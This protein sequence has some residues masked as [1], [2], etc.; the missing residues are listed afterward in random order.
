[1]K[2]E[3]AQMDPSKGRRR[4]FGSKVGRRP[5]SL[6]VYFMVLVVLVALGFLVDGVTKVNVTPPGDFSLAGDPLGA[7]GLSVPVA[8][9]PTGSTTAWYCTIS[10]QGS[11]ATVPTL[12]LYNA[13]K[14]RS[15]VEIF[16]SISSGKAARRVTLLPYGTVTVP[17]SS[18]ESKKH[19]S[20]VSVVAQGGRP[21]AAESVSFG[22]QLVKS[23]CQSTPGF[24]W[25]VTGLYTFARDSANVAIY[26]PFATPAVVDVSALTAS[27]EVVPGNFQGII[28]G[29]GQTTVI[30]LDRVIPP[31]SNLAVVVRARSGRIVVGSLQTRSDKYARGL[32]VPQ[33]T[34]R[35]STLWDY[36]YVRTSQ[37]SSSEITV[38]NPSSTVAK[39][40]VHLTTSFSN[41]KSTLPG[42]HVTSVL[43]T[44]P[45]FSTVSVG[46]SGEL[47]I[48]SDG[49]FSVKVRSLDGVGVGVA[50]SSAL[51]YF[52]NSVF[53]EPPST[54]LYATRWLVVLSS[55]S[56]FVPSNPLAV[57]LRASTIDPLVISSVSMFDQTSYL[58]KL[59]MLKSVRS[60]TGTSHR[61]ALAVDVA[62][63]T[64]VS[65]GIL[66]VK[67]N[68]VH[69]LLI[70]QAESPLVVEPSYSA[71]GSIGFFSLPIN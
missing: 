26:N 48:P 18:F 29:P 68:K 38:S 44:I 51:N 16:T 36:S 4:S 62:P 2:R 49:V 46:L 35:P 41:I 52:G 5:S 70:V 14:V 65:S 28:V 3:E 8:T 59:N 58:S 69:P 45:P 43:E 42:A 30:N 25:I 54:P 17:M 67:V 12:D 15:H 71:S 66:N 10:N 6:M 61:D 9:G 56:S 40:R 33:A 13:S 60:S 22:S 27:G 21:V 1:M 24:F 11:T 53:V 31:T 57:S 50:L 23:P 55:I 47:A 7:A 34:I 63:Y 37:S 19:F 64:V 39:V 32:A 20:G